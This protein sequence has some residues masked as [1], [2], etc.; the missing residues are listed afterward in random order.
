MKIY[1]SLKI[2]FFVII[3]FLSFFSTYGQRDPYK[4][5]FSKTSIW[6]MPVHRD[7]E[8]KDARIEPPDVGAALLSDEDYLLFTP[9]APMTPVYVNYTRWQH[10]GNRCEREGHMLFEAP[11]PADFVVSPDNWLGET[12]NGGISILMPDR[13]TIK[14]TQPFARCEAGGYATSRYVWEEQSLYGDGIYGAHGGS[15][16]SAIGGAIRLGELVPDGEIRHALK[17]IIHGAQFL[18]YDDETK[19]YRWPARVSDGYAASIYGSKG[20]PVKDVRMGSLLALPQDLNLE[21]LDFETGNDGPAMILARALR[22]YGA[23]IIDDPYAEALM[24][25][26]EWSPEGRVLDEFEKEWGYSFETGTHTAWGRDIAKIV[27]NLHVIANNYP[28]T[29]GGGPTGDLDNR[30]AEPACDFGTPGSGLMCPGPEVE[31]INPLDDTVFITPTE[32]ELTAEASD[33]SS[34]V[35]R[36]EFYSNFSFIGERTTEPFTFTWLCPSYGKHNIKARAYNAENQYGSSK[37]IELE[38]LASQPPEISIA[39]PEDGRIVDEDEVLNFNFTFSDSDGEVHKI[40]LYSED[41]LIGESFEYPFDIKWNPPVIGSHQVWAVAVDNSQTTANSDT[42][43]LIVGHCNTGTNLI[44]NGTFEEENLYWGSWVAHGSQMEVI[45]DSFMMNDNNFLK[46]QINSSTGDESGLRL[47]TRMAFED[48]R[49]Y[50]LCFKAK[51]EE[52]KAVKILVKEGGIHGNVF[53]QKSIVV[54]PQLSFHGPYEFELYRRIEPG[55][56]SFYLGSDDHDVWFDDMR[57]TEENTQ[58]SVYKN[59]L[60]NKSKPVIFPNPVSIEGHLQINLN[61]NHEA[62]VKIYNL[63]GTVIFQKNNITNYETLSVN[64]FTSSEGMFFIK[65]FYNESV[66]VRNIVVK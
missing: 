9:D 30:L 47:F 21:D 49:N 60:E 37:S 18:F 50:R 7:A 40:E 54:T 14:Q 35:T 61:G 11:I 19:G 3:L 8:Y 10:Y 52:E 22:N 1:G 53:W 38:V 33:D 36:V 58:S 43:N 13:V 34:I 20:N 23:Y 42:L 5:P 17:I 6:N 26:T 64:D 48:N 31:I 51:A 25:A 44:K 65:L 4:W 59:P 24:F 45:T 28:K 55:E 27:R 46:A 2:Q 62:D 57:L 16:L 39:Y 15:S 12:P 56:L 41:S 63:N 66:T 32:I 29:I